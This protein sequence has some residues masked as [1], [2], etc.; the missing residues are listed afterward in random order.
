MS[1]YSNPL[2][3]YGGINVH[4]HCKIALHVQIRCEVLT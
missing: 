1:T 4:V 3:P 2:Y